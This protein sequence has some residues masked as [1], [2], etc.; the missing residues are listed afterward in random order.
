MLLNILGQKAG[1]RSGNARFSGL[2]MGLG[3]RFLSE[4]CGGLEEAHDCK[5]VH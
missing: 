5:I 3:S 1:L 4:I 2:A